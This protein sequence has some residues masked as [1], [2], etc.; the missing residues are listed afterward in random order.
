MTV[1]ASQ[2]AIV[3]TPTY[4][5]V[6]NVVT[7]ITK[8]ASAAVTTLNN[9]GYVDGTI[10]RFDI[11]AACGMPQIDQLTSPLVV[12][13]ATTFTTLIDSTKFDTFAVPT[14]PN[15]HVNICSLC[16]PVG[17]LSSTLKAAV[18]NLL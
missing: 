2:C 10:V 7:A 9:H 14:S 13:G 11:P 5:P 18:Q 6:T 1:Q 8:A 17:E 4:G 12:T 15:P 3:T 16:V